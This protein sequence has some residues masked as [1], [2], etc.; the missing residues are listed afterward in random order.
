MSLR[1]GAAFPEPD[2]Q[3]V[4]LVLA[5][6]DKRY[7]S[8]S[9]VDWIAAA[10]A[11]SWLIAGKRKG[12][13]S[14]IEMQFVRTVTHRRERTARRKLREM[15]LAASIRWHASKRRV[16]TTYLNIAYFG[17]DHIG[18]EAVALAVFRS[19]V[20]ALCLPRQAFLAALLVRPLPRSRTL[21]WYHRAF[22]RARWILSRIEV[23]PDQ[24]PLS[25]HSCR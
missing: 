1:R 9:G 18:A 17:H 10:R 14:T 8:H 13:A 21:V 2:R 20:G 3:F 6:E 7:W 15:L 22:R 4:R 12:G 25:T 5:A 24:R 23:M 19:N 11:L 16:L